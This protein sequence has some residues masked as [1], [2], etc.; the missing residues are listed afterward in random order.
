MAMDWDLT[1]KLIGPVLGAL[2]GAGIKHVLD[3]R[4]RGVV[5]LG[6]MSGIRLQREDG[7]LDVGSHSIILRNGG[8]KAAQDDGPVKVVNVLPTVQLSKLALTLLWSL[9]GIG[10]VTLLYLTI[11]FF[12]WVA[13]A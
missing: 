4:S 9:I 6:H 8:R 13:G 2:V 12:R 5:F 1:A 11:I 10:L 7:Q 3:N